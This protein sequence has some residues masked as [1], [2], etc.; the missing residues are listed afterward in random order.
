MQER[1]MDSAYDQVAALM[2]EV[3]YPKSRM[4]GLLYS[5][6][7]RKHRAVLD[8]IPN[9][10][11]INPQ[12]GDKAMDILM[13][14][15]VEAKN[16]TAVFQ[17]WSML[18]Y[19]DEEIK[20]DVLAHRDSKYGK[21]WAI[22]LFESELSANPENSFAIADEIVTNLIR[23]ASREG[24]TTELIS[25]Y[26]EWHNRS[27]IAHDKYGEKLLAEAQDSNNSREA[28]VIVLRPWLEFRLFDR[29]SQTKLQGKLLSQYITAVDDL[30]LDAKGELAKMGY[31]GVYMFRL[32][33]YLGSEAKKLINK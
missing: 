27:V 13:D 29:I 5:Q 28:V 3:G 10:Y 2:E 4:E 33:K 11:R 12:V 25:E 20:P 19:V 24:K 32:R 22:G 23:R 17:A 14:T 1:S 30:G 16:Y 31:K 18:A 21:S 26:N 15:L 7:G 8:A 6:E 9:I